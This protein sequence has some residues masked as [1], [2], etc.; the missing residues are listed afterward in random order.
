MAVLA[1]KPHLKVNSLGSE[2]ALLAVN[3]YVMMK[4][5][6]QWCFI[7]ITDKKELLALWHWGDLNFIMHTDMTTLS[8]YVYRANM[9]SM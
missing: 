9:L 7:T 1:V 3:N 8:V 5:I 6:K 4:L 2:M